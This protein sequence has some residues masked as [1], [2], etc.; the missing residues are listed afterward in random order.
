MWTWFTKFICMLDIRSQR[1]GGQTVVSIGTHTI[2]GPVPF[3]NGMLR[4][5]IKSVRGNDQERL[6]HGT[7]CAFDFDISG[8]STKTRRYNL[9]V[10]KASLRHNEDTAQIRSG[11][12]NSAEN[13]LTS[14]SSLAK[15]RMKIVPRTSSGR[16]SMPRC[17]RAGSVRRADGAIVPCKER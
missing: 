3:G 14:C 15:V 7:S 12:V 16:L 2:L 10:A 4:Y 17:E 1:T 11:F 8:K 6:I 13:D 5:Q 9:G